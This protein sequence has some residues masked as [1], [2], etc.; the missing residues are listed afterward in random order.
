MAENRFAKYAQQ[1]A[2]TNR[3]AKYAPQPV[4]QEPGFIDRVGANM[5]QRMDA[6]TNAPDALNKGISAARYAVGGVGDIAGAAIQTLTPDIVKKGAAAVAEGVSNLPTMGQSTFGDVGSAAVGAADTL[7]KKYPTAANLLGLGAD[8]ATAVPSAM[9]G[10]AAVKTVPAAVAATKTSVESVKGKVKG[11][12][13]SVMPKEEKFITSDE[14][15]KMASPLFKEAEQIGGT[16]NPDV[17]NKFIAKVNAISPETKSKVEG[18]GSVVDEYRKALIDEKS[19]QPLSLESIKNMDEHLSDLITG[20]IKTN[21]KMTNKGRDLSEIQDHFRELTDA[22][23]ANDTVGKT[24][25][26]FD[27][28]RRGQSV[29]ADSYRIRDIEDIFKRAEGMDNE[30]MSI[31]TQFKRLRDNPK[32]MNSYPPEMQKL[33]KQAAERSLKVEALRI[34]G[35]RLIS[36]GVGYAGGGLTGAA[37]AYPIGVAARAAA[38]KVQSAPGKQLLGNL[39]KRV[40]ET[41]NPLAS[42]AGRP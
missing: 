27:A 17:T 18:G 7:A 19:N 32:K 10:K 39:S 8:V 2:P 37:A 31:K 1:T 33:I 5:Q 9:V 42:L 13:K 15:R 26:A 21:G 41:A 23:A 3:F 38:A 16:L 20:E 25:E 29:W 34:I 11:A 12:V 6:V 28:W 4:A 35:S 14:A 36:T 22:A 24:A 40:T 30:A